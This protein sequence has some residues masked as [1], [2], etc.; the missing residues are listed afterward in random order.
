MIYRRAPIGPVMLALFLATVCIC[1]V[2]SY[3]IACIV[4]WLMK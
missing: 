2:M 3:G 1:L 4:S